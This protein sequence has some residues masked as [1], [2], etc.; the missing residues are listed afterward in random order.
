MQINR[1]THLQDICNG[2]GTCGCN[3][4]CECQDLYLGDYCELC[5]GD[6]KICSDLNCAQHIDCARCAV[7]FFNDVLP[8]S[9]LET[10]PELLMLDIIENRLPNGSSLMYDDSSNTFRFRLPPGFCPDTC[11]QSVFVINGTDNVQYKIDG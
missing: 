3:G 11:T 10:P 4:R 6:E 8:M 1:L 2:V 9:E 5:S 7:D